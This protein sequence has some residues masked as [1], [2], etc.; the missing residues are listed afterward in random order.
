[1]SEKD[2]L[3]Q[4]LLEHLTVVLCFILFCFEVI[5]L[6]QDRLYYSRRIPVR[7]HKNSVWKQSLK[8]P[9]RLPVG[10]FRRVENDSVETMKGHTLI[11]S[12]MTVEHVCM[13]LIGV[14]QVKHSC[15]MFTRTRAIYHT[16][17]TCLMTFL[18]RLPVLLCAL[19]QEQ[20][21]IVVK[22]CS[23]YFCFNKVRKVEELQGCLSTLSSNNLY[24]RNQFLLNV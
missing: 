9:L 5:R 7:F 20:L 12:L 18:H 21:L 19:Q 24:T 8:L 15:V 10:H 3:A 13:V 4:P 22:Y 6:I 11:K 16:C 17:C 23:R 1:M 2:T 14:T